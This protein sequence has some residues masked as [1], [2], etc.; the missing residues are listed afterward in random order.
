MLEALL[1]TERRAKAAK[2]QAERRET[3][4]HKL[5]RHPA[6]ANY[7]YGLA[8]IEFLYAQIHR[9][10]LKRPLPDG[11]AQQWAEAHALL[12]RFSLAARCAD[13]AHKAEYEAKAIALAGLN[14][15]QC[16]C[17]DRRVVAQ[18]GNAKGVFQRSWRA[19]EQVLIEGETLVEFRLCQICNALSAFEVR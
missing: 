12:G 7:R 15:K 18:A 2:E 9:D 16:C 1:D 3:M 17:P 5:P 10:F 11:I 8:R 6:A 4:G 13:D 19:T 14:Q